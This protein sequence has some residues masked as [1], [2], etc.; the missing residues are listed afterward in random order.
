MR[1]APRLQVKLRWPMKTLIIAF[2]LL[3]WTHIALSQEHPAPLIVTHK[4][5]TGKMFAHSPFRYMHYY[6]TEVKNVSNGP[7]K[8]VWFEAY[9]ERGGTWHASNA[10]GRVLRG[11]EFSAWYTE[12]APTANGVIPPGATAACDVNWHGSNSPEPMKMKWAFIAVDTSGNDYYVEAVVDHS[13][14]KTVETKIHKNQEQLGTD[15]DSQM[16]KR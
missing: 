13:I 7:L 4:L 3:F 10:L 9:A 11:A 6:R 12:G 14:I 8:I 5:P 2:T 15:H 1:S 16:A